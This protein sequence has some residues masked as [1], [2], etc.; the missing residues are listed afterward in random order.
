MIANFGQD[1][2]IEYD[3]LDPNRTRAPLACTPML[4]QLRAYSPSFELIRLPLLKADN[5]FARVY[6][7]AAKVVSS[8]LGRPT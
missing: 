3:C 7:I 8:S 2:I 1:E 5:S 6:R 4:G